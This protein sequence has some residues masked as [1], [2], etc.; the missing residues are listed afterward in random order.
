MRNLL[1]LL[2]VVCLA[3][4]Q[5][6]GACPSAFGQLENYNRAYG[7]FVAWE[8]SV[9]LTKIRGKKPGLFTLE[10]SAVAQCNLHR[11]QDTL[12]TLCTHSIH[13]SL[14][15]VSIQT[16]DDPVAA[17]LVSHYFKVRPIQSGDPPA[18]LVL[19]TNAAFHKW[20]GKNGLRLHPSK[21]GP[22]E[23]ALLHNASIGLIVPWRTANRRWPKYFT[24]C[25]L[26]G[27]THDIKSPLD[28]M[29]LDLWN[30]K[31]PGLSG[32]LL[33]RVKRPAPYGRHLSQAFSNPSYYFKN[34][35]IAGFGYNT[36][37]GFPLDFT[38]A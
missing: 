33:H 27:L 20:I 37:T 29:G 24:G 23:V 10:N 7:P 16:R 26:L 3:G 4:L 13:S 35:S 1:G 34:Y 2:L 9:N 17:S 11:M 8:L 19:P 28:A 14:V 22:R 18:V 21:W 32:S 38:G 36:L 25:N 6:T 12:S 30:G 15:N 31:G 5:S